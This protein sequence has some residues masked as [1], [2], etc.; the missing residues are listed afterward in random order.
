MKKFITLSNEKSEE[1]QAKQFS[2]S[3]DEFNVFTELN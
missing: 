1:E 2:D 3:I